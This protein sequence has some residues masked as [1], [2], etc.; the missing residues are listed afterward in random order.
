VLLDE[1][2]TTAA[3]NETAGAPQLRQ[4]IT[5]ENPT[6]PCLSTRYF[7]DMPCALCTAHEQEP[8]EMCRVLKFFFRKIIPFDIFSELPFGRIQSRKKGGYSKKDMHLVNE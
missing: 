7:W 8:T 6:I 1:R 2:G 4:S 3:I 5:Y